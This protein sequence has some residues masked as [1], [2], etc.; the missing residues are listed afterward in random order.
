MNSDTYIGSLEVAPYGMGSFGQIGARGEIGFDTRDNPAYP[1]RG[2]LVR[3][4]VAAYPGAWDVESAFGSVDGEARAYLTA[5]M[6]IT[7]TLALRVGGKRVWGT[8]PF[9]ESAF[10]GGPGRIGIGETDHPLRGFYKNRFAGDAVLYGNAELRLALGEIK[11]VV[12]GEIG[13]FGAADV[14]RVFYSDDLPGADDWHNGN[15]GGLW[16]SF[17]ERRTTVSVA[18]MKGRDLT[19]VY[20]RAGFMF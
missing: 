10:L 17:L 18:V 3:T 12:P 2:V 9:H 8:Y 6:P 11:V 1:T 15:G 13:V 20:L 7:P 14:G 16:L 4:T 19:G 5:P